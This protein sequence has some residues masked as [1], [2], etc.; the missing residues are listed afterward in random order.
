MKKRL[1]SAFLMALVSIPLVLIGGIPFRVFVGVLSILAYKEIL[2]LKGMDLYPKPVIVVGLF[3][4]ISLVFSSR[5]ILYSGIGLDFK[6]IALSVLAFLVPTVFYFGNKR[7]TTREAFELLGFVSFLGITFNITSNILIYDKN[8]FFLIIL[9]T[10]LTDT[11]AFVTGSA[12]GRHKFTK[13]SPNKTIEGCVGGVIMGTT[14]STIFYHAFIGIVPTW[15]A[16]LVIAVL[17]VVCEVGD[18]F[19]SAIKREREIKDF[20]NLIP[21]HGGILDRI[22]SLTF[23]VIAYVLFRGLI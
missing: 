17:S 2:D 6:Y 21:G 13:I 20:S 5:D 3:I 19:Y 22:D 11:F 7:Y 18:L 15:Q 16:I 1:V 4:M 9:I 14:L 8:Y 10:I 23:V 12:I